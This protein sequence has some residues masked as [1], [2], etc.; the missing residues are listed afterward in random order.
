MARPLYPSLYQ[1]NTR[2]WLTEL[3]QALGRHATLHAG[4]DYQNKLAR[5]WRTTTSQGLPPHFP[6]TEVFPSW[7]VHR[8]EKAC[9]PALGSRPT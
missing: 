9:L 4:L 3:S 1:V 7:S 2:V 5:F 6:G 8:S